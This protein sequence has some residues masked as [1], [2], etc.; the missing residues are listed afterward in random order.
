MLRENDLGVFLWANVY[1]MT[2]SHS[3]PGAWRNKG[4]IFS[5]AR[6]KSYTELLFVLFD[7]VDPLGSLTLPHPYNPALLAYISFTP[8]S[9]PDCALLPPFPSWPV[10]LHPHANPLPLHPRSHGDKREVLLCSVCKC[11]LVNEVIRRHSDLTKGICSACC[12]FSPSVS[13]YK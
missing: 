2:P 9:T 6:L 3:F 13:Q 5:L 8:V 1:R 12:I 11:L 10:P 7:C 4:N